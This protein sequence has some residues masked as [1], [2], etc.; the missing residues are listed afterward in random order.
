MKTAAGICLVGPHQCT[1]VFLCIP[2][3]SPRAR[4]ECKAAYKA[5]LTRADLP[6]L[7]SIVVNYDG[8]PILSWA[9]VDQQPPSIDQCLSRLWFEKKNHNR[10][11]KGAVVP[12]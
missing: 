9:A 12:Y 1:F 2:S 11:A 4:V 5:P 3:V 10:T 6:V 8:F 7:P